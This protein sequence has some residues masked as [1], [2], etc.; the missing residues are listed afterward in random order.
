MAVQMCLKVVQALL[1]D[2]HDLDSPGSS[3]KEL[4]LQMKIT[5]NMY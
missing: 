5:K 4:F 3:E 2:M 1:W